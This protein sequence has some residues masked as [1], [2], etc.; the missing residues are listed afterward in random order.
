MLLL[1]NEVF[2][3]SAYVCYPNI[4][5]ILVRKF[6]IRCLF[7]LIK[8]KLCNVITFIIEVEF[9]SQ[10]MISVEFDWETA[11]KVCGNKVRVRSVVVIL[12]FLQ[13]YSTAYGRIR[14]EVE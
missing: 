4:R 13:R 6:V 5:T 2:E 3:Y 9:C 8:V 1:S 12:G 7:V 14:V 10:I 11:E